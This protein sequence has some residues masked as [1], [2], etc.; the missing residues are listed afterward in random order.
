[1]S[2]IKVVI[3]Q[4]KC[5]LTGQCINVCPQKAIAMKDGKPSIDYE[6]C[7]SDGLCI[8]ACPEG[9][10]SIVPSEEQGAQPL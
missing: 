1:M 9:A 5:K 6:R 7:D 8:P 10:I 3:N 2:E 4:D